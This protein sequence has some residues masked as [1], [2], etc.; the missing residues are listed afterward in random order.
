[1]AGGIRRAIADAFVAEH[2][3]FQEF[4]RDTVVPLLTGSDFPG[5]RLLH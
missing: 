4:N 2:S 5:S 3:D 1:V